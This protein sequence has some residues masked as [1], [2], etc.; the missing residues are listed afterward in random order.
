MYGRHA[1]DPRGQ[2]GWQ[3][4]HQWQTA[5]GI[6]VN[7]QNAEE[8]E[9]YEW[10]VEDHEIPHVDDLEVAAAAAEADIEAA[11]QYARPLPSTGA[12]EGSDKSSSEDDSEVCH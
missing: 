9:E 10:V 3:G 6:A 11:A 1:H 7:S 2:G 8:D 4:Q 12:V 5:Q